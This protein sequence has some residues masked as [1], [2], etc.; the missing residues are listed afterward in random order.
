MRACIIL[1]VVCVHFL[2]SFNTH[3]MPFSASNMVAGLLIM[4]FHFTREAFM[5]ITGLVL[6]Y[7]YYDRQFTMFS[8]WRKRLL[9]IA[10]PY[11]A[12]TALYILYTG[13]Y[14]AHFS[15]TEPFLL[16]RFGRA[17]LTANQ[18]FMYFLLVSMQ[19]YVVFPL[20]LKMM[21]KLKP[22]HGWVFAI[23]FALEV[24]IMI[25]NQAVLQ[26]VNVFH[27]PAWLGIIVHY[28]DRFILTYQ[29]WFI[30]GAILAIRYQDIKAWVAA[31]TRLVVTVLSLGL[32]AVW[33]FYFLN[34]FGFQLPDSR[35]LDT[36]QP[37]MVPF[38]LIVAA[39]L[40]IAG[41]KWAAASAKEGVRPR[42]QRFSRIIRFFGGV[43]FGIFLIHPIAI[44]YVVRLDRLVHAP[45]IVHFIL[46]PLWIA[47][48]YTSAGVAAYLIGKIPFVS[49]IVGEKT[50]F[51]RT[52]KLG[53]SKAVSYK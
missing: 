27:L 34:R 36:L 17:L 10:V 20:M 13:T 26:Y 15:W 23:S 37:I 3:T 35:A 42:M 41:M 40:W 18:F 39:V 51:N 44:H 31:R 7:T 46:L 8:F 4:T 12:W 43:S 45:L 30:A 28:R 21:R 9:L 33:G 19:L 24:G 29:F 14:L 52:A 48:A 50:K 49:Y 5:F 16:H 32:V 38:S 25:F 47:L 2:S 22:Y 6:F 1:G 53:L 11:V